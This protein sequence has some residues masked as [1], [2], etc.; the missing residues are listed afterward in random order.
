MNAAGNLLRPFADSYL[1]YLNAASQSISAE[2][3]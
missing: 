3:A 2:G 1:G